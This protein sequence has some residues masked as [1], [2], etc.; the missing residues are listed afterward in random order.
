MPQSAIA[1]ID[2]G[3]NAVRLVIY[4]SFSRAPVK[5]HNERSLCSLGS[6]LQETGRL[7][8]EGLVQAFDSIG[9][10]AGLLKA[11]GISDVRAVAT[12]AVRDAADGADFIKRLKK[13]FGLTVSVIDGDREAYLSALGVLGNGQGYDGM[14]GD[15]GGGSLELIIARNDKVKEKI[16]LPIGSHRLHALPSRAARLKMIEAQLDTIPFLKD[17]KSMPFYALGGAWRSMGKAHLYMTQHPVHVLDHYRVPGKRA[18][19]F[20]DLISRQSPRSLERTAGLSKKRVRDMAVA[21]MVMER[22]F[23]R[24]KPSELVFS[25][26]GLREGLIFD[27]LPAAQKKQDPLVASCRKIAQKSSRFENDKPFEH[28]FNWILPLFPNR[29]PMEQNLILASCLL[30]DTGW[31]E[32][33]DYQAEITFQRLLAMPYYAIDHAGR[34]MLALS[35]YV[36]YRGYL[37]TSS[38]GRGREDITDAARRILDEQEIKGAMILGLAQRLAYLLTGG[39]LVLLKDSSFTLTDKVLTL[40]LSRKAGHLGGDAVESALKDVAVLLDRQ[41]KVQ[42]C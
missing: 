42:A 3:S 41:A 25:A 33:E 30:S 21:A 18:Y 31:V 7:N 26:T 8:P 17:F 40:H 2:I 24:L 22:L 15:Y 12:A 29:T 5:I 9:R 38:R 13:D 16:S 14:I 36:R 39:A 34:A 35:G 32:H 20:A 6:G 28:L 37:R 10:F 11:L 1:I 23:A 19:D 27:T 4:D